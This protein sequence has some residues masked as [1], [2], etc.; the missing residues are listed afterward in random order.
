MTGKDRHRSRTVSI[1]ARRPWRGA[2]LEREPA[3]WSVQT[4]PPRTVEFRPCRAL[5]S[6]GDGNGSLHGRVQRLSP[7][8]AAPNGQS[9][10]MVV[11]HQPHDEVGR[12]FNPSEFRRRESSIIDHPLGQLPWARGW[13]TWSGGC[14]EGVQRVV[15]V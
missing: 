3:C 11:F 1:D 2:L 5:R 10:T 15:K 13:V 7:T 14:P 4:H 8:A 12:I 6:Y 9:T